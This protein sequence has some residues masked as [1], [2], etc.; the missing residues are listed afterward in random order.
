MVDRDRVPLRVE[1]R[2]V[3]L[4]RVVQR[5]PAGKFPWRAVLGDSF[6]LTS[7][8]VEAQADD[9]GPQSGTAYSSHPVHP[10]T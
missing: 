5:D 7:K 8:L 9:H 3:L 4:D 6:L 10:L 1:F 2:E